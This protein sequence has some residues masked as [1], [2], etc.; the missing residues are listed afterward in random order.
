[1]WYTE[2]IVVRKKELEQENTT[3]YTFAISAWII[4]GLLAYL[5]SIT[6]KEGS[7]VQKVLGV[8]ISILL[9]PLYFVYLMITKPYGYCSEL[10]KSKT[11]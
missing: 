3:L 6:C 11:K 9:G 10:W 1:M 8:L 4:L 5:T 2:E 7:W